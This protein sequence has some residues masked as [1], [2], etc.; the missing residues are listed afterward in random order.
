[1]T[2][3]AVYEEDRETVRQEL[4]TN[5]DIV[6]GDTIEYITNNQE[7]Y[8]KYM[9]ISDASGKKDI[10]IIDSYDH[11]TGGKIKKRKIKKRKTNKKKTNKKRTSKRKI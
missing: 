10:K 11:Q 9:V 8:Q 5:P 7:G 4:E 6:I 3:Y 2:N 1:M